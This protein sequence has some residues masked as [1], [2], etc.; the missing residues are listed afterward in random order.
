MI[1]PVIDAIVYDLVNCFRTKRSKVVGDVDISLRFR[2]D[3]LRPSTA[4]G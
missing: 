2:R 3:S 1:L 4:K